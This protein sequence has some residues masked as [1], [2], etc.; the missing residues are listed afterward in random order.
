MQISLLLFFIITVLYLIFFRAE[1]RGDLDDEYVL[2][3]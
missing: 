1:L 2:L 3:G